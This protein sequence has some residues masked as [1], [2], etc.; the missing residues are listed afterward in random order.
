MPSLL[1]R[2]KSK[3][4]IHSSRPSMHALDGAYR[5]LLHG[6]SLDFDDLREY[7][8]GDE[9]RDIDWRATARQGTL[10]VKRTHATRRHTVTFLVDTGRGMAAHGPDDTPKSGLAVLVVGMLGILTLRH[11]D[12]VALVSGDSAGVRRLPPAAS[13]SRL[14]RVLR[15]IDRDTSLDA[16]PSSVEDLLDY[17]V[18]ALSRRSIL[19]VV[20]DETPISA[21]SERLLRRL[22]VQ[23]DVL[24]ATAT[25][26]APL[27]SGNQAA[28]V[29]VNSGWAVPDF[30]RGDAELAAELAELDAAAAARR[31]A[32]LEELRISHVELTGEDAVLP[33]LL[34]ML[35]RRSRVR[36]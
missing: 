16:A 23:H 1:T 26:A 25:D 31:Q 32:L 3:L 4:F 20:T 5:S 11:G 14:E 7:E 8:H 13:E 9:V 28:R 27:P 34:E 15:T 36:R 21:E 29:D 12:E 24:W 30:L 17:A 10:L 2:V 6:R 35:E 33:A 19:V 18:R 22:R